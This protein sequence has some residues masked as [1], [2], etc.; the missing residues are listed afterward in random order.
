MNRL[1]VLAA[2][3]GVAIAWPGTASAQA[4]GTFRWQQ[5][6]YCNV[7]TVRVVQAGATFQLDGVDDQCGAATQASSTRS[8]S[9]GMLPKED[10]E[11]K[12]SLRWAIKLPMAVE[13]SKGTLPV[14]R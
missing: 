12:G 6:P 14:S 7:I 2:M 5:L 3:L 9:A 13:R 10:R 4:L 1:V 11:P 8:R